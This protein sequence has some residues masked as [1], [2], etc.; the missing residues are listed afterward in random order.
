MIFDMDEEFESPKVTSE[1]KSYFASDTYKEY[2]RRVEQR[3]NAMR[4]SRELE[5]LLSPAEE[6][7]LTEL[8]GGMFDI[9]EH[10]V[11]HKDT[12]SRFLRSKYLPKLREIEPDLRLFARFDL[13]ARHFTP[14]QPYEARESE[15]FLG[16]SLEGES[17]SHIDA[18]LVFT[19]D[20]RRVPGATWDTIAT[21]AAWPDLKHRIIFVDQLQGSPESIEGQYTH[22]IKQC[23]EN[24]VA[25]PFSAFVMLAERCG[26]E[27]IAIRKS[28]NVKW[29]HVST[30]HE[31]GSTYD[32]I[33][34]RY[35]DFMFSNPP[36][37][38]PKYPGY[39]MIDLVR[40][41]NS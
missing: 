19:F 40:P 18:P 21:A 15:S 6:D 38:D 13:F 5:G 22:R 4:Q 9:A 24:T 39:V 34:N 11:V 12:P 27:K 23:F 41:R 17:K 14:A 35:F 25:V 10:F 20:T 2:R 36:Y 31:G 37:E 8:T 32:I 7:V 16:G 3:L 28:E 33:A 26:M 29:D 30:R 1:E